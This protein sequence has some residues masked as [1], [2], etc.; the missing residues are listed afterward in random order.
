M[1]ALSA[2]GHLV[3]H[4]GDE[5]DNAPVLS[6]QHYTVSVPENT[7]AGSSVVSLEA[8]DD[9]VGVNSRLF[10]SITQ[11]ADKPRMLDIDPDS[12]NVFVVGRLDFE[13]S[14]L[15]LGADY[16]IFTRAFSKYKRNSGLQLELANRIALR[17]NCRNRSIRLYQ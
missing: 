5:N 10:Y 8:S 1:P 14:D 15:E 11:S 17:Q 4:I 12:G 2:E 6:S 9:D 16:S 7:P 3:I 13:N